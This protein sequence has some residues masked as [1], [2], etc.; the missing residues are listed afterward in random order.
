MYAL[1]RGDEFPSHLHTRRAGTRVPASASPHS[2]R[3][4]AQPHAWP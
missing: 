2:V 1:A 3:T 4:V